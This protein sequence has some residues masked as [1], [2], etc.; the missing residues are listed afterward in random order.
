V[1]EREEKISDSADFSALAG[2]FFMLAEASYM[3][4][5]A[6]VTEKE[7]NDHQNLTL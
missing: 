5:I 6:Y 7:K 2:K 4:A 3:T 1:A